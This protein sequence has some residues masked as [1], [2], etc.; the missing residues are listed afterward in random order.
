LIAT[1]FV[2]DQMLQFT[3]AWHERSEGAALAQPLLSTDSLLDYSA[4]HPDQVALSCWEIGDERNGI[5][6]N[7]SRPQPTALASAL[8]VL[9][10]YASE[11]DPE[12]QGETPVSLAH[13]DRFW[14]PGTDGGA[15]VAALLDARASGALQDGAGRYSIAASAPVA[16]AHPSGSLRFRDL[17]RAMIQ[18]ADPAAMDVVIEHLGRARLTERVLGLGFPIEAVPLPASAVQLS[19]L[20]DVAAPELLARFR[21]MPRGTHA[22]TIWAQFLQL[23]NDSQLRARSLQRLEQRASGFSLREAAQLSA[24]L[25]AHGTAAQY[26][27]LME[28]IASGE[29]SSADYMRAQLERPASAANA[30]EELEQLGSVRAS[31]PGVYASVSYGRVLGSQRTRVLAVMLRNLPMG[32]WLHLSSGYLLRRFEAELLADDAF[33]ERAKARLNAPAQPSETIEAA[34]DFHPVRVR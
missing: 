34:A 18:H 15:H 29:L 16:A 33:F 23:R 19:L 8:L 7:A 32:V 1:P 3:R 25:S 13:W 31:Q 14:F 17:L 6:F 27:H 22:D 28:Q 5:S 9:A 4:D 10:A 24:A 2:R 12:G 21:A 11:A 20:S 26:A 30:R